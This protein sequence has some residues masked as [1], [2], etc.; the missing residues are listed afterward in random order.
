ME[1]EKSLLERLIRRFFLPE[2]YGIIPDTADYLADLSDVFVGKF[3]DINDKNKEYWEKEGR[4]KWLESRA[5]EGFHIGRIVSKTTPKRKL[6][7]FMAVDFYMPEE[8]RDRH[9][10]CLGATGSG[11]TKF[12]T[13]LICQDILLGNNV[14]ILNPKSDPFGGEDKAG[15][16]LFSYIVQACLIAGRLDELLVFTPLFPQIS[17]DFNPLRYYFKED[18]LIE[19]IV[20]GVKTKDEFYENVAYEDATAIILGLILLDL[21]KGKSDS[22]LTIA[23]VKKWIDYKAMQ[24]LRDA[25]VYFKNSPEARVR[26]SIEQALAII[27]QV[28]QSPMDFFS[29]VSSSLRTVLTTLTAGSTGAVIGNAKENEFVRR[30]ENNEGVIFV[31]NTDSQ[32]MSRSNK[33]VMKTVASVIKSTAGRLMAVRGKRLS[34]PLSVYI[35]EGHNILFFGI[36]ELF[37]KVRAAGMYLNFFD[38]SIDQMMEEV[39]PQ[40]TKAILSNMDT[41]FIM[42]L[43]EPDTIEYISKIIPE[44]QKWIPIIGTGANDFTPTMKPEKVPAVE[45]SD[46]SSLQKR[47]FYMKGMGKEDFYSGKVPLI[48]PPSL[49]ITLPGT[50]MGD[51]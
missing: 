16:E 9:L 48:A 3:K 26:E 2:V 39:G 8:W 34:R 4:R 47:R 11:K 44:V 50:P 24:D 41:W 45:V 33:I 14:C 37:N 22:I 30:I 49:R 10:L 40:I 43:N 12:M 17:V 25:I 20:S 28:V 38:Q 13:Y 5:K 27:E 1:K 7:D 42:R 51:V 21:A 19:H 6:K 36:Q 46:I 35:D 32:I 18:E 29:K 15:N 31:C 23:D